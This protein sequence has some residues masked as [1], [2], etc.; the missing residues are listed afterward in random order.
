[1]RTLLCELS[2]IH[3]APHLIGTSAL[4]LG[5]VSMFWYAFRE[6]EM[7]LDLFEMVTG[8]RHAH[9]LLPDRRVAEDI[10]KASTPSAAS[11][12]TGCRSALNDYLTLLDKNAIWLERTKG[13]GGPVGRRRDRARADRPDPARVGRRLGSPPDEPYLAYDPHR[14]P[15]AGLRKRRRLRTA[16]ACAWTRCAES[17]RIVDQCPPPARA[18]GRAPVDRR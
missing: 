6:R 12:S 8:Q 17:T 4:E 13:V 15:G 11:S 9:P 10:P 3:F 7:I 18:H 5:A 1:M 2:R 16:T 14:L